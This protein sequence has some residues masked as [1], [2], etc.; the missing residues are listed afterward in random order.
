M[1]SIMQ[2]APSDE[3]LPGSSAGTKTYQAIHIADGKV[4]QLTFQAVDLPDAQ[5]FVAKLG[6]G[7]MGE[8]PLVTGQSNVVPF[9]RP[10][11]FDVRQT[12]HKLGISRS[13]L[14]RL[15]RRGKLSRLPDTRKILITRR[16]IERYLARAA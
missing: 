7:L 6:C 3:N 14:D 11:A 9:E 2:N 4:R 16:S 15:V 10:D 12:C 1:K 5:Q 13:S 8:A